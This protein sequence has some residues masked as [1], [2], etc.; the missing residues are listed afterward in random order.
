MN[1]PFALPSSIILQVIHRIPP[2]NA[3]LTPLVLAL[4]V[5]QLL[6]EGTEI[7]LLARLLDDN[8]LPVVADLVDDPFSVLAEL[9]LVEGGYA[10][11]VDGDT[12]YRR[13]RLVRVRSSVETA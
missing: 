3:L 10:V 4:R 9:E 8:L 13:S 7:G 2:A 11:G 12:V 1:V 6:T 5:E